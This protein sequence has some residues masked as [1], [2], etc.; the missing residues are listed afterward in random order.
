MART[1]PG[2]AILDPVD[3]P[4]G[5]RTHRRFDRTARLVGDAGIERLAG[6]TVTVFGV[7]YKLADGR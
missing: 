7:G 5:F 4:G 6:A 3:D 2:F 1:R